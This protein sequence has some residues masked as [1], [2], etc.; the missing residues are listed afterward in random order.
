MTTYRVKPHELGPLMAKNERARS[1]R[2]EA[3]IRR[4]A[5][6]GAAL[7]RRSVPVAHSEL[8][9]SVHVVGTRIIV[10]APHAAAVERGSRPHF[11]PLA[12]LIKWVKLR[13]TQGLARAKSLQRMPGNTTAAHARSV[14]SQIASMGSHG[15]ARSE[16]SSTPVDAPERVARAIQRAIGARGTKPHWYARKN[17][18]AIFRMTQSEVRQALLGTVAEASAQ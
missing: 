4:A 12:P 9:D 10:D 3:A 11:P 5:R 1:K 17:L 13:G 18:P 16:G 8:R 14:A 15:G 2:I 6:R 7:I